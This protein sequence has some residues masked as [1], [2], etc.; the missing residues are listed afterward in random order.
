MQQ[1]LIR[2]LGRSGLGL[3]VAALVFAALSGQPRVQASPLHNGT[4]HVVQLGESLYGIAA[5]YGVSADAIAAANGIFNPN[6][7]FAGQRLVIPGAYMPGPGGPPPAGGGE[8]VVR[9]GDTLSSI[10]WQHGSSV[11]AL[12]AAN[13]IANPN[14][15]YVGQTLVIPGA[16]PSHPPHPGDGTGRPAPDCGYTYTVK[17]GDSLSRIAA[18]HGT[19]VHALARANALSYPYLIYPGQRLFVPCGHGGPKPPGHRPPGAT[20]APKPTA[21]PDLRP[22]ACARE[23]QIVSPREGE[24]VSGT[25]Q[26][27]GTADIPDFQFYKVEYALGHVPLDSAFASINHTYGTP[28]RD[29]VLTTWYTGNMPA[30]PFTLRLTVVDDTGNFPRPCDVHVFV[31]R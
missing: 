16:A 24:H 19:T 18:W 25:V 3:L 22:A 9:P 15:I 11:S 2:T 10:A 30:Q 28:V 21:R 4:V 12:M 27:V 29:G 14:Y 7:I 20:P 31:D 17:P 8:Y 13:G 23:V 1:R 5:A 6:L 26:I